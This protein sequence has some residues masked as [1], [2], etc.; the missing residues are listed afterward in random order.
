MIKAV[1]AA[2]I[3]AIIYM[4]L[5]LACIET[6]RR[7]IPEGIY[8]NSNLDYMRFQ[9]DTLILANAFSMSPCTLL[10][11]QQG[12]RIVATKALSPG[13]DQLFSATLSVEGKPVPLQIILNG[14]SRQC[15][16]HK[17]SVATVFQL[18]DKRLQPKPWDSLLI[19]VSGHK[20]YSVSI[21]A[22]GTMRIRHR[23][24]NS[25]HLPPGV[26]VGDSLLR[27]ISLIHG[28]QF[29][30]W[31]GEASSPPPLRISI[32]RNDKTERYTGHFLPFYYRHLYRLLVELDS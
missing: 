26:T 3:A 27:E 4:A 29:D 7:L 21:D 14:V 18:A 8:L 17:N 31:G 9:S 20:S 1:N 30:L 11:K 13:N 25:D 15:H 16:P 5:Q 2:L 12:E 23:P 19:E 6:S 32:Y 28:A 24:E 22:N 10:C